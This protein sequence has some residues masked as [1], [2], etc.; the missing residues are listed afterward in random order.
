DLVVYDLEKRDDIVTQRDNVTNFTQR[1]NAGRT[2]HRGVELGAGV[3]FARV[4][5]LDA[6]WSW[7]SQTY[8]EFLTSQGDFSGKHIE[9]APRVLGNTRLTWLPRDRAG[10]QPEWGRGGGYWLD[11]ANTAKY[12]GYDV[13]NLRANW[14]LSTR[15]A[16]SASIVNVTDERYAD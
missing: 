4:W 6:A 5:R 13:L 15:L 16:L 8:E 2:R 9:A 7:S 11:A 3:P 1:V 10:L 12:G 14:A